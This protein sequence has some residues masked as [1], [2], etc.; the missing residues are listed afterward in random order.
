MEHMKFVNAQQ[1]K[2]IHLFKNTKENV[3]NSM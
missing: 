2:L 3:K 1:A